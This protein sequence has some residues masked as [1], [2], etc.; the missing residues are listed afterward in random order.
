MNKLFILRPKGAFSVYGHLKIAAE[1][2]SPLRNSR[3]VCDMRNHG[4]VTP[5][6]IHFYI[7]VTLTLQL[8]R[9]T[10]SDLNSSK[11]RPPDL[12][13]SSIT[14]ILRQTS[15]EKPCPFNSANRIQSS[16][17]FG[18]T[19]WRLNFGYLITTKVLKIYIIM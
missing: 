3:Q 12:S 2:T 17:A 1:F 13:L 5:L 9:S 7:K 11:P 16:L 8:R 14:I 19:K 4:W 10:Q 6:F 15:F 18:Q